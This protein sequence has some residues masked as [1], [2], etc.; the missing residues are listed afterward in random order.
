MSQISNVENL[1]LPRRTDW[2]VL[3]DGSI[4]RSARF[5]LVILSQ[6]AYENGACSPGIAYLGQLLDASKDSVIV[7]LDELEAAGHLSRVRAGRSNGQIVL[8]TLIW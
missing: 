5:L 1:P 4:S 8:R 6:L 3:T 7:W 2:Q